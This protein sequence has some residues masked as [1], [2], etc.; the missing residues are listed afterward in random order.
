MEKKILIAYFSRDGHVE[1]MAQ[2][3]S[4]ALGADIDRIVPDKSYE[5]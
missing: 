4:E 1:R 2:E 5:G 3:L